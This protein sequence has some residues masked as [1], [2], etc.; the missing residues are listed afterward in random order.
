MVRR[1][2]AVAVAL[3]S[4]AAVSVG[5]AEVAAAATAPTAPAPAP[6]ACTS[7]QI[8]KITQLA[9]HPPAVAPGQIATAVL[10]AVNCTNQT[11][12]TSAT[13]S[14]RFLGASTGIPAGCPAIDPLALPMNF[15]PHAQLTGSVGYLVPASCTATDLQVTVLIYKQGV[16]LAQRSADLPIIQPTP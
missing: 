12:Q 1:I 5:C 16:L 4:A 2:P 15:A 13:W 14:G 7:A 9:F 11:Q 8:I 6:A 3:L 10:S